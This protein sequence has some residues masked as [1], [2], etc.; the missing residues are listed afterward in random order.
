VGERGAASEATP[1]SRTALGSINSV[2][3]MITAVIFDLGHTIMNELECRSVPLRTRPVHLMPGVR[4]TLP[5]IPVR[6]GIWA[7]TRRAREPGIRDWLRRG[8]IDRYF[9]W[10]VTSTDAGYRKPDRRFFAYAL[11]KCGL[12]K[13]EVLFVGNQLNTDIKGSNDYGIANVWMSG[14]EYRSPDDTM[15]P[16]QMTATYVLPSLS[17]LP[18]LL[19]RLNI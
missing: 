2:K 6:M 4:E 7:N 16:E 8:H 17:H 13:S 15:R 1:S 14:P 12:K 9:T 3:E 10:V 19:G 5:Q 18:I 11:K